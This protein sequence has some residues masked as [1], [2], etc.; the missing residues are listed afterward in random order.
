MKRLI[1]IFLTAVM[2]LTLTVNVA[3]V[4]GTDQSLSIVAEQN[5]RMESTSLINNQKNT[6][7]TYFETSLSGQSYG[8]YQSG[9]KASFKFSH[10]GDYLYIYTNMYILG[11]NPYYNYAEEFIYVDFEKDDKIDMTVVLMPILAPYSNDSGNLYTYEPG[12]SDR[13]RKNNTVWGP[14]EAVTVNL[15]PA[16]SHG[17]I[18]GRGAGLGGANVAFEIVIPMPTNVRAAIAEGSFDIGLG[19]TYLQNRVENE[20]WKADY[21]SNCGSAYDFSSVTEGDDI[22]KE[23][24]NG[25]EESDLTTVTLQGAEQ[26]TSFDIKFYHKP[27]AAVNDTYGVR[28]LAP[29]NTA[30][31]AAEKVGFVISKDQALTDAEYVECNTAYTQVNVLTYYALT[32]YP[33]WWL[34]GDYITAITVEG[35]DATVTEATTF[36]LGTYT[37]VNGARQVGTVYRVEVSYDSTNGVNVS[38]T[39]ADSET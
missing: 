6:D 20:S 18:V 35:F 34:G 7:S 38:V 8:D 11:C 29:L 17:V 31:L 9:D 13:V 39:A 4:D 36:Y 1:S 24:Y 32:Q 21:F 22:S 37:T 23:I 33:S 15:E 16:L 3:A 5:Q 26:A 30:D 25:V 2:M 10:D 28:F 14:N 12:A 19:F 27:I